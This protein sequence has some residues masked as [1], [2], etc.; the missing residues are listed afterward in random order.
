MSQ[1]SRASLFAALLALLLLGS[2][3]LGSRWLLSTPPVFRRVARKSSSAWRLEWANRHRS[4]QLSL[5][6]FDVYHPTRGWALK[7]NLDGFPMIGDRRLTTNSRG[8]RSP[9]EFAYQS[10]SGR[11]RVLILGDSFTF[12]EEVSDQD[13]Y[14]AVLSGLLPHSEI[15]N[16]GVHGYG[17]DQMLLYLK[18]EGILYR[19]DTVVLGY[20]D[21]DIYRDILNFRDYAKP[22]FKTRNDGTLELQNVPI[23]APEG[24]LS[25]EIF[26]PRSLDLVEMIWQAQRWRSGANREEAERISRAILAEM[27][28]LIR[29][30][31]AVPLFLYLPVENE[32]GDRDA[33][34]TRGESFLKSVCQSLDVSC[35]SLR[36]P[37]AALVDPGDRSVTRRH[38]PPR[39]HHS[40][41]EL[42]REALQKEFPGKAF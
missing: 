30:A 39:I 36:L 40:A 22:R 11:F 21:E 24:Y 26:F 23:P 42:L 13:S 18:E 15:L 4:S 3:E 31:G 20:V 29:E 2:L 35:P 33:A 27:V 1:R 10:A 25:R 32:L 16:L 12:G 37:L 38:W 8:L 17:L 19:P 6:S 7:P 14:P 41:A 9:S 28:K 5:Y 34:P